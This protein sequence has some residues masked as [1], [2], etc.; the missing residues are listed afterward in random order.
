MGKN[1]VV[2]VVVLAV[3]LVGAARAGIVYPDPVGGWT[4]TYTGDAATAGPTDDFD[5]LDGTWDHDNGSDGWDGSGIGAGRPGGHSSIDGYLRMQ[6]TGDPRDYGMGDPG[7]NRKLMFGHS[8]TGDLGS[9]ADTILG[10]VTLSFRARVATGPP[11]DDVHPDGG[12]GVA[13]W[14]SGGDGYVIH[15]GGKGNIS[16]RQSEGGQIISLALALAS[17]DDELTADGLVMNKLNGNVTTGDVDLQGSEPGTVNILQ[18]DPTVWHEFWIT[19]E[20]DGSATG[21][22][23][24]SVYADGSLTATQ[25]IVTAGDG[26]DY[27]DSYLAMGVG[28]TPQ[29]GAIDVDFVSYMPGVEAPI[30]EPGTLFLLGL[31][32]LAAFRR[33][34]Q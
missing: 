25:F 32:A 26:S 18:L 21:T 34:K 10:G 2:F 27:D 28:A 13:P 19:I 23:V 17:D 11:L 8:I 6:D 3:G 30:P 1:L 4:Y 16:I 5:S 29:S 9:A 14:P 33:R 15:D 20:P 31:G 7:S 12:G 24:V 22:H